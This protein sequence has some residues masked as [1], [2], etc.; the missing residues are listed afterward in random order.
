M[1]HGSSVL[2]GIAGVAVSMLVG[3]TLGLISG[4]VGN[5]VDVVV[6]RILD[7]FMSIPFILLALAVVGTL[8]VGEGSNVI[9]LIFI[10]GLT[11]WVTFA[12]VIRGEVLS[13]QGARLCGGGAQHWTVAAR[14]SP[15][16]RVAQRYGIDHR[17]EHVADFN[18]NHRRI[19]AQLS[20]LGRAAADG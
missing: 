12:R 10:L 19:V 20:G 4:Y 5:V 9:T 8:G 6:S 13:V 16:S 11:G 3:V 7:T 15:S 14:H 17:P 1:A 2:V 18:G